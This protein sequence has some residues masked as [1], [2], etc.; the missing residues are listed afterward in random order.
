M[1]TRTFSADWLDA[2]HIAVTGMNGR[3]AHREFGEHQEWGSTWTAVFEDGGKYWRV[4]YQMANTSEV[5]VDTW[6]GDENVV[7]IEVVPRGTF[8]TS[9]VKPGRAGDGTCGG[10]WGSC[11]QA[12]PFLVAIRSGETGVET[13]ERCERHL[14]LMF[15]SAED[16]E[17]LQEVKRRWH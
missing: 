12:A 2:H 1:T 6:F 4:T 11:G 14:R 13:L 10:V 15:T 7:A 5:E 17:R 3:V 8:V 9:W 16:T